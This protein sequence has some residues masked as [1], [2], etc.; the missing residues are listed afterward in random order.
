MRMIARE[1]GT[2]VAIG[3]GAGVLASVA[4]SRLVSSFLITVSPLEPRVAAATLAVIVLAG[5]AAAVLPT[6]RAGAV[7]LMSIL[8][9]E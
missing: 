6:R 7:D 8:R 5:V 2:L 4:S 9:R 1:V 3:V